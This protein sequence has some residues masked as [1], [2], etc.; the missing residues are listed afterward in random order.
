MPELKQAWIKKQKQENDENPKQEYVSFQENKP[1]QIKIN[2]EVEPELVDG[3]FNKRRV[4]TCEDGKK[5]SFPL[6]FDR[7]LTERLFKGE[8]SFLIIKTGK[9]KETRYS[10]VEA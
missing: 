5:V 8:T 4:Y 7:I 3:K 10:I 2:V 9:E 1:Q 6:G